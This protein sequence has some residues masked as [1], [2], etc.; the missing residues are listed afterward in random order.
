MQRTGKCVEAVHLAS[1]R[2]RSP[3]SRCL[4]W[5]FPT[6]TSRLRRQRQVVDYL[7]DFTVSLPMR[8]RNPISIRPHDPASRSWP[9][10]PSPFIHRGSG[11]DWEQYGAALH[12]AG[13]AAVPRQAGVGPGPRAHCPDIQLYLGLRMCPCVLCSVCTRTR[14]VQGRRAHSELRLRMCLSSKSSCAQGL[15]LRESRT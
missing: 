4:V 6:L 13:Q 12:R 15:G 9:I 7:L 2:S 14:C 5:S 1:W 3:S 11:G 10:S 8:S